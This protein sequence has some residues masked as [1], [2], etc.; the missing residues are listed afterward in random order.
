MRTRVERQVE[1]ERLVLGVVVR[2]VA[3]A[4]DRG[5]RRLRQRRGVDEALAGRR[6]WPGRRSS[7]QP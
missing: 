1:V 4:Q 2:E 6:R 3:A 5:R 7:S